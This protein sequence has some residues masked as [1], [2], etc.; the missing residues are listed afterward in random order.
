MRENAQKFK[1]VKKKKKST[2]SFHPL[3][4]R[5]TAEVNEPS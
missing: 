4:Y 3:F 5:Q 1:V 2:F